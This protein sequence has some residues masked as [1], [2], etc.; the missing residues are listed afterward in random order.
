[1]KILAVNL[2]Y[3]WPIDN[4]YTLRVCNL[5]RNLGEGVELDLVCLGDPKAVPDGA[6][7]T[8]L[9]GPACR[10]VHIVPA[11]S[12]RPV[13]RRSLLARVINIVSPDRSSIGE[14]LV[15]EAMERMV[16]QR[17]RD[18][19]YDL[20][21]L[22]GLAASQYFDAGEAAIPYL[23]DVCDSPSRL[24]WSYLSTEPSVLR[25]PRKFVQFIWARSY[26][27]KHVAPIPNLVLISEADA[28][29][30]ARH[31]GKSNTWIV[32]N[33]VDTDYFRRSPSASVDR[34]DLLF[35]GAME[36]WPNEQAMLHFIR[37]ILPRIREFAPSL[38]LIVAGRNPSRQLKDLASSVEGIVLTGFVDD[39]RP[40]FERAAVYVAPIRSGAGMKNKILE[41]WAMETPIVAT[42]EATLGIEIKDGENI[43]IADEPDVFA[44]KTL[45]LLREPETGRRLSS[46]GR[47]WVE[48]QYS[49]RG[50]G[51]ALA[52]ICRQVTGA[53]AVR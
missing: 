17:Q 27:R 34:T 32:S 5:I 25:K 22:W 7:R 49:W 8:A 11:D 4:G 40:Y 16:R 26:E 9:L 18:E 12:L 20:V 28:S 41:S 14:P 2:A 35:T 50:R 21:L 38:R 6:Q 37:A 33:G 44:A 23:V 3:P 15:S 30:T 53:R 1:M 13:P 45:Q 24:A 42:K 19:H 46:A 39:L 43:F 31:S 10:R 52:D 29:F 51:Q 47:A 48:K 36:Y